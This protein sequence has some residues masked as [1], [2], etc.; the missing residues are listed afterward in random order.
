L[1]SVAEYRRVEKFHRFVTSRDPVD[2]QPESAGVIRIDGP[3]GWRAY[4][5]L[6]MFRRIALVTVIATTVAGSLLAAP[7]PAAAQTGGATP[8]TIYYWNDTLLELYRRQGGGP[9]PLARAA[10]L[11]HTGIFNALNTADWSQ[12]GWT[13]QGFNWYGARPAATGSYVNEDAAA[14][15]VARELLMQAFPNHQTFIRQRFEARNG[16]APPNDAVD[17][18]NRTVAEIR[19]LRNGDGWDNLTPYPFES[20][21]GSWQLTGQGC[22]NPGSSPVNPTWG[23]VRPFTM[24]SPTQFRQSPPGGFSSYPALLASGL[25]AQQVNEV[26]ALGR[27]DSTT[28]TAQQTQIGWFWANDLDGTY[29]PPGQLLAH[30]RIV[31]EQRG[32]TDPTRLARL[33]AHVSMAMADAGIAAWDMKYRTSIDLWRPQTAIQ[34]AANDGN[35][36]TDPDA[37]GDPVQ[38]AVQ[39]LLP[40]LGVR[41]RHV[42]VGLGRGAAGRVRRLRQ[43]DAHDRG[44]TRARGD[45]QLRHLHP[46]RG[47][48]RRE[49]DLPRRPLPVRRGRGARRRVRDRHTGPQQHSRAADPLTPDGGRPRT[50]PAP[51]SG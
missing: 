49:P 5:L 17:L 43:R 46:G 50:R 32:V 20:T 41:A 33:F 6:S 9:G 37:V 7:S 44:S 26:K 39:P 19:R 3:I 10:A 51:G 15:L 36:A 42:R 14:G 48:E 25:Y 23:Q 31:A 11:M 4:T 40:R 28:R 47:G 1:I 18:A 35:P 29:K 27:F 34:Q 21:L 30:T 24:T 13:G 2:V 12:R 16:Q 22:N 8:A 45:P 38:P